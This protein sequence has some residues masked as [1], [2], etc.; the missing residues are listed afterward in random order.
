MKTTKNK[1]F[2]LRAVN[3][4]FVVFAISACSERDINTLDLATNFPV[5]PEVFIDGFSENLKYDAWGKV[6]AFDV[7]YSVKYK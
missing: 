4:A 3:I 7:D 6:T 1:N 2:L 5:T